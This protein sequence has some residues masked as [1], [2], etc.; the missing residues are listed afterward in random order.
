MSNFVKDGLARHKSKKEMVADLLDEIK[1]YIDRNNVDVAIPLLK[2]TKEKIELANR[3]S[4][5]K[6]KV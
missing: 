3:E 5:K 1:D 4:I 2:W 6:S